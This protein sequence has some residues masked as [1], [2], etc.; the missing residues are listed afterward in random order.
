M[1]GHACRVCHL[2]ENAHDVCVWGTDCFFKH[3]VSIRRSFTSRKPLGFRPAVFIFLVNNRPRE[4]EG[5]RGGVVLHPGK[6]LG[7]QLCCIYFPC[8][9]QRG[10]GEERERERERESVCVCYEISAKLDK[11][12]PPLALSGSS[13]LAVQASQCSGALKA[14]A[15]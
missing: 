11:F 8:Q 12:N 10:G 15:L 3:V 9:Q 13:F 5:G 14:C 7:F 4:R 2:K 6:P 1:C